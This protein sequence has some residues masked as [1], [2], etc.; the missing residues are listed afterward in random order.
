ME[1]QNWFSPPN[2][3]SPYFQDLD[4]NNQPSNQHQQQQQQQSQLSNHSTPNNQHNKPLTPHNLHNTPIFAEEQ[5]FLS[6]LLENQEYYERNSNH[7]TPN[8]QHHHLH[9]QPLQHNQNNMDLHNHQFDN[10]NNHHPNHMT[11]NVLPQQHNFEFGLEFIVPEDLNFNGSSAFP[12]NIVDENTPILPTQNYSFQQQHHQQQHHNQHNQP[13]PPQQNLNF[14]P[15]TSPALNA[16][17]PSINDKRRS[18][19]SAFAPPEEQK[20][21]KRRTPHGTPI[22]Q[23]NNQKSYVSPS[24]KP[25]NSTP[26]NNFEKLP[27]SSISEPSIKKEDSQ[28][29]EE[30]M[31][32]PIGKPL[33]I[34]SS[35]NTPLMGFTMGKL[36]E[37][38]QNQQQ[39]NKKQPLKRSKS[40]TRK[41]SISRSKSSSSS[42]ESSSTSSPKLTKKPE[43]LA[44]K[45]ASHKLAEQ[46]RRNRMNTAVAEL[47]ALIPQQYHDEVTIP[48]KA[49]TVEL[50]SK[51]INALLDEIND[52]KSKEISITIKKE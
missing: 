19:S 50:A 17:Q 38:E 22:L 46:G 27:E 2:G 18:T 34:K 33:E 28:P 4:N 49:T 48:S 52:L 44:T 9:S 7:P 25:K 21:H 51:Y 1:S 15:L 32:P 43:K 3:K 39:Q 29:P 8:Q 24:V 31:L 42:A 14:E 12:P 36:A 37:E 11:P 10:R 26:F 20:Q 47:G 13:P 16:Q 45:K 5:M 40:Q 6:Q 41:P 30:D 35:T 23:A